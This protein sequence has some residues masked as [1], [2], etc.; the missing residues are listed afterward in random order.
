MKPA[1]ALF[2]VGLLPVT[3]VAHP[4]P[5][6]VGAGIVRVA[7][8]PGGAPAFEIHDAGGAV[9]MRIECLKSAQ[10][11]ADMIAARLLAS[12]A[13]MAKVLATN[14]HLAL[15]DLGPVYFD[16]VPAPRQRD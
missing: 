10:N 16:C 4:A 13:V 9:T 7:D 6:A 15:E 8:L 12:R 1:F 2:A 14:G 5:I 3:A 11:N